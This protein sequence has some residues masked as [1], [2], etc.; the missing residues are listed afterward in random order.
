MILKRYNLKWYFDI[1]YWQMLYPYDKKVD[2]LLNNIINDQKI[3]DEFIIKVLQYKHMGIKQMN[4]VPIKDDK[5]LWLKNYPYAYAT[6]SNI[7]SS[8]VEISLRGSRN[9]IY[10]FKK[11]M[12]NLEIDYPEYFL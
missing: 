4:M 7:R 1:R 9:T 12:D 3:R 10:N 2:D 5:M 6:I 11:F 8:P